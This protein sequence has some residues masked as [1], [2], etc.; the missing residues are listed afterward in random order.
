MREKEH[1]VSNYKQGWCPSHQLHKKEYRCVLVVKY[2]Q[3][4]EQTQALICPC[5]GKQPLPFSHLEISYNY[6]K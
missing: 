2:I 4:R 6:G 5:S 1:I 3:V